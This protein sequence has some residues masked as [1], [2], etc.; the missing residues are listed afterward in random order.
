L[1]LAHLCT[2]IGSMNRSGG[3]VMRRRRKCFRFGLVALLTVG[4]VGLAIADDSAS[5]SDDVR[6]KRD[7]KTLDQAEKDLKRLTLAMNKYDGANGH[8]PPAAVRDKNGKLLLSWRVLLLPYVDQADLYKKFKLDESWDSP[9]NTK[10]I[11]RMP[12]IYRGPTKKL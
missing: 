3:L 4:F 9:H 10:L 1:L 5:K 2:T 7:A 8:L 11:A 6:P 12:A